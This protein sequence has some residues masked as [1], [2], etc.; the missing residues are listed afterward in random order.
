MSGFKQKV[1]E[2]Y[3]HDHEMKYNV[4]SSLSAGMIGAAVTNP[5]ECITVNK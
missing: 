1:G 5:L 4:I 3:F 2:T